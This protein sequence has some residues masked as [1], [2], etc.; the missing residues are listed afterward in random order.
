MHF[1]IET[2]NYCIFDWVKVFD[3]NGTLLRHLCGYLQQDVI[4]YT[5]SNTAR[6]SF[7]SDGVIN[8]VGFLASWRAVPLDFEEAAEGEVRVEG[9]ETRGEGGTGK[10]PKIC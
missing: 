9:E 5:T 10:I 8:S 4:L 1:Q 6:V 7:V 2:H 3:S